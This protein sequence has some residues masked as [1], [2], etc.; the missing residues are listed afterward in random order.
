MLAV[1]HRPRINHL[2]LVKASSAPKAEKPQEETP[3]PSLGDQISEAIDKALPQIESALKP[4]ND[5]VKDTDLTLRENKGVSDTLGGFAQ[6]VHQLGR[7]LHPFKNHNEMVEAWIG[8]TEFHRF[9]ESRNPAPMMPALRLKGVEEVCRNQYKVVHT[10]APPDWDGTVQGPKYTTVKVDYDKTA[11]VPVDAIYLLE[12]ED[13]NH[14]MVQLAGGRLSVVGHND[15]RE[16]VE[17]F[18]DRLDTWMGENNFYKNKV[19]TFHGTLD[20]QEGLKDTPVNWDDIALVPGSEELIK[21]NTVDFFRNLEAYKKNTKFPNRNLLMAGPP[22]TGKSMV[23]DIL[24]QELEGEVT[25]IHV[26]SKSLGGPNSV[27]GIFEAA[28]EMSPAVIVVEDLDMLGATGRNDNT[29]RNTLN[30]M[31]NQVSGVFDNTGLVVIGST[32]AASQFDQAMLRPLRFSNVIP[33][34]LPDQEVRQQILQ[35]IT[36]KLHMSPEV[37]L[38]NL[39]ERTDKFTGAGLTELKELA[40]QS[41]IEDRSFHEGNKVLLR[42]QDWEDGLETIRLKN[43]YLERVRREGIPRGPQEPKPKS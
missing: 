30:E 42:V 29:R 12:D 6:G 13:Q 21:S 24:M 23:N 28:R 27:A 14:L 35:K 17:T 38:A 31:L 15:Q 19:L 25:F 20:F 18:Y 26:T 32:N 8:A 3:P 33:M 41:A 11:R 34:P 37:D 39:A 1:S 7:A 5:V 2:T 9:T 40:I 10:V 36:R 16:L 22:G 43:E 4:V